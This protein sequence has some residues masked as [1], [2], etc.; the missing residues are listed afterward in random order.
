MIT[1]KIITPLFL[2]GVDPNQRA[3]LR[4]P[5][6]KGALRVWYRAID[7]DYNKQISKDGPTWEASIFG[8]TKANEGQGAFLMSIDRVREGTLKWD[9]DR[10][11]RLTQGSGTSSKNGV[12]Y[13]AYPLDTGGR[14]SERKQRAYISP[15]QA[16]TVT[17]RFKKDP[18]PK[19]RRAVAAAWWLLG[20]VGGVGAR[21]RR[22]F[23]TLALQKWPTSGSSWSEF[24]ELPIAHGNITTEKW[25]ECFEQGLKVLKSWYPQ[26]KQTDIDH[27]VIGPE[28]CFY[29]FKKGYGT[30]N[31]M[32]PWENAL[33][34]A[35]LTMQS[36]RQ[37]YGLT[38]GDYQ[39]VKGHLG[40]R[41]PKAPCDV[42]RQDLTKAP[43]RA[44]FGLP[45]AF[46]YSSM[47][48][49]STDQD[50]KART[51]T[52]NIAFQGMEHDRSASPLFIRI[53]EIGGLCYAFFA[54]LNASLLESGEKIKE[55]HDGKYS[56]TPPDRQILH[57]FCNKKLKPASLKEVRP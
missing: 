49:E 6:L 26:F 25:L 57:D 42:P 18:D 20:H 12:I 40:K 23:G 56:W 2:G 33:N 52:P 13:L 1:L 21:S 27:T 7:P 32:Q 14:S 8:G 28:A 22:G 30:D 19:I 48:Y 34:A 50:G 38:S 54:L 55:Q 51:R 16:L 9:R 4:P 29:L 24:S 44:A 36:F 10:Y 31:G 11:Q 5:S 39:N 41:Y 45:L 17:L 47:R 46:Q 43:D 15:G 3:E 35:G 53:V 37:R